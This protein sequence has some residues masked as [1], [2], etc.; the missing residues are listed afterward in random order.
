MH[1]LYELLQSRHNLEAAYQAYFE[2]NPI[3]FRILGFDEHAS[4]EHSSG[5]A[6][7]RDHEC[8]IDR[9]PDFI[10]A[11]SATG[12]V[13][14]FELKTP[15]L[16]SLVTSRSDGAREKLRENASRYV[17]QVREYVRYI[18]GSEAAR[19]VVKNVLNIQN[20]TTVRA[21]VVCGMASE[22]VQ[23]TVARVLDNMVPP[24]DFLFFDAVL[25]HLAKA[26]ESRHQGVDSRSGW[27]F[28]YVIAFP[29]TQPTGRT[30]ICD[31]GDID[32]H[33]V[34]FIR[35]G[36]SIVFEC[37]DADGRVQ[38]LTAAC[39][40]TDAHFVKF[41]FSND[42]DGIYMSL[43]V[44]DEE[45]ALH[46]GKHPFQCQPDM[47]IYVQG[48][49]L[50]GNSGA[51]FNIFQMICRNQTLN[52]QEKLD[53]YSCMCEVIRTQRIYD[54]YQASSFMRSTGGGGIAQEIENLMPIVRPLGMRVSYRGSEVP[55]NAPFPSVIEAASPAPP[56]EP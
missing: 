10:C 26:Y 8:D 46:V 45:K 37:I 23:A 38:R 24:V 50:D 48:A 41:E 33:R 7:P 27:F 53:L 16:G 9:E 1:E 28:A 56:S 2:R 11:R 31:C 49:D 35:E 39:A 17:A 30:Y 42:D 55:D 29:E 22:N 5:N 6:L 43:Q 44:D 4:F 12:E 34:S 25:D 36:T 52:L 32:R 21:M 13:T 15:F 40:G 47:T 14:V 20:I 19:A 18:V 51:V 3:V 54:E